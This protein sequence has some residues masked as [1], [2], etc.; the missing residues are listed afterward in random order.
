MCSS[1]L[2]SRS[3]FSG[4][5]SKKKLDNKDLTNLIDAEE[6]YEENL[7]KFFAESLEKDVDDL[8]LIESWLTPPEACTQSPD[9][10]LKTTNPE[11]RAF[12]SSQVNHQSG[13]AYQNA[14]DHGKK[15]FNAERGKS[16]AD[17]STFST[18]AKIKDSTNTYRGYQNADKARHLLRKNDSEGPTKYITQLSNSFDEGIWDPVIQENMSP[19][20]HTATTVAC[21]TQQFS[22][23]SLNFLSPTF[24]KEN[25]FP[26]GMNRK[27]PE[28]Y[29]QNSHHNIN[30]ERTFGNFECKVPLHPQKGSSN[31]LPL[32]P[33]LQN[34]NSSYNGFTWL[35]NKMLNPIATSYVAYEKQKQMNPQLPSGPLTHSNESSAV[36]A[37][38]QTSCSQ[39]PPRKYGKL[40]IPTNT[41]N[42]FTENWRQHH[43]VGQAENASLATEGHYSRVSTNDSRSWLSQKHSVNKSTKYHGFHNK[44]SQYNT[45]ER[46]MLNDN[47]CKNNWI[48]QAN[49]VGQNCTQ[50]NTLGRRQEQNG[51]SLS[52]FINP[53]FLPLFPLVPGYK[54]TPA[55]PPL[56]PHL[57]SSPANVTFSPLPFPLSELVDI[58][59]Y[60]DFH[61]LSPLINDLLCGDTAAPYFAFPLP[62]NNYRP[63]K[64]RSGPANELHVRLEECY[65]QWR[66][67]ERERKKVRRSKL[68]EVC[69]YHGGDLYTKGFYQ[70]ASMAG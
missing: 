48:P 24:N 47:R 57:F 56:N 25:S 60:D 61:H 43:L 7:Q 62:F 45:N 42:G 38:T 13:L 53:S 55:F 19:K 70:T 21:D 10:I 29:P 11:N 50:F 28:T 1:D 68:T 16:H 5:F 58:F 14:N 33:A 69:S 6:P 32:K 44:Q 2:E 17:S 39:M 34:M 18:Q 41:P 46:T 8:Y 64:N 20:R 40:Q 36:Q 30:T 52:D 4:L 23:P 27:F 35:D 3:N 31:H 59:H 67:L 12:K 63:P 9:E 65:E 51:G 37:V 22:C 26:A 66:S 49:Y 54:Q 15:Q